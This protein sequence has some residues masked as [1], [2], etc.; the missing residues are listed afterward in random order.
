MILDC[1]SYDS[2]KKSLVRIF[3]VK[4]EELVST[5][6]SLSPYG[7]DQP[8]EECIYN[9][10]CEAFGDPSGDIS[11]IWFHGT[12]VEDE[13]L[14]HERGILPK[15]SAREFIE[16]R[17]RELAEG[18]GSSGDNP[19]SLSLSGKQ[20]PHDEGPFAFL[21]KD[22]AIQ[23]SGVNHSYVEVPEMVEDIAGILLG[24]NYIHLVERFQEVSTPYIV[25]FLADLKGGEVAHALWFLKL[26]EDGELEIDAGSIAN[27]F[28]SSEGETIIP[29]KIQCVEPIDIV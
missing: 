9:S 13:T 5:L 10:I 7:G 6:I 29:E 3:G 2:A 25:S 17:L 1:S 19:F 15:S 4:E 18:L 28:F 11:V 8:P 21:I 20:G 24:E 27:T 12:R 22:V 16:P 26:V 23:V 14:F